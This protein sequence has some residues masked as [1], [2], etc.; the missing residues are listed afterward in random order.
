MSILTS[1]GYIE[2]D[3]KD[4]AIRL[5]WFA[6]EQQA[7]PGRL[8]RRNHSILVL[9]RRL[10]FGRRTAGRQLNIA[11]ISKTRSVG[12]DGSHQRVSHLGLLIESASANDWRI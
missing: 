11:R 7:Q 8:P 4:M 12:S 3:A 5:S 6:E 1:S 10:D 2:G 9:K